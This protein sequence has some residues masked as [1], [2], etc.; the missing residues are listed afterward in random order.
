M[1]EEIKITINGKAQAD[2]IYDLMEVV[3]DTNLFLP[4]MF[5]L[6]IQDD[7]DPNSGKMEYIDSDTFKVGA[8]VKIEM[9]TDDIPDESGAIKAVLIVGEITAIEPIFSAGGPVMLRVRGY[10]RSHRLT[11]GKK[12]R[13]F[14]ETKDSDLVSKIASEAGL[15]AQVDATTI[16]YDYVMQYNQTDWE[17]LWSRARRL[18]YQIHTEE[19]NLY[20]KKPD[21]A[22]STTVPAKLTWGYNLR[23]FEPRLSLM[24][25][26]SETVT[27]GWDPKTKKAIEG[28]E[29]SV[30]KIV[31]E[32]GLGEQSGGAMAKKAFGAAAGHIADIPLQDQSQAKAI[33]AG[34][35]TRAEST[36]IQAEGECAYGDPRLLAGRIVEVDGVGTSFSGKYHVTEA[37]HE[38][39]NGAY[40][41]YFGVTGQTPNTMHYLLNN[42]G[43]SHDTSRV[44]GVVTAVVTDLN[45]EEKLGR[46]KVKFPW[47]PKDGSAEVSSTWARLAVPSGGKERGFFFTP[48]VDDEVLV[49]FE[50]GDVNFPYIVGALWNKTDKPPAGT[51]DI[52]KDGKVN[53]RVIRSR[54]GHLIIMDD[55]SG[56]EQIT[57]QDKT[58]KNSIVINSKDKSMTIK[59]EGDLIFEAGGK[60]TVTSK[61]DVSVES[62]AKATISSQSALSV[63]SKQKATVKSGPGELA[64][65]ASGTSL[66]GTTVEVNGS[67]KTDV[68]GGAMVQIQGGIVKIN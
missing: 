25:Q 66:K 53:Q 9:E 4:S 22:L 17:F 6:L 57:I 16:Q 64:L 23:R 10:D 45:D 49:V 11:R 29:T 2:L 32:I 41:V 27:T 24:G 58:A 68:K 20:F 61:G 46:V 47:L 37:R 55:T 51:A 48:E 1:T 30:T 60:F 19:K 26:L 42:D 50:H 5:S 56:K 34:M 8:E 12:T 35:L 15:S 43:E 65:Q 40:T 28:K 62:K 59:A 18:G 21:A 44:N 52:V 67:A 33:A 3:V 63:E 38:Y 31:P 7:P 36:F 54:S 13:T 39:R 14:L